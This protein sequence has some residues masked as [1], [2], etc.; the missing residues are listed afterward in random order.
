[1]EYKHCAVR[2]LAWCLFSE[3]MAL[4][5]TTPAFK[6]EPS[7]TLLA[8]LSELDRNPKPLHDYLATHN[9]VLLGSYFECLWQ[10]FFQSSPD[11][12]LLDHHI[13]IH[14]GKQTLGE[15]DLLARNTRNKQAYHI[16]LAVKF[17]LKPANLSGEQLSHWLGP[18]S[19]D[20]LDLKLHKLA[21]KQLPFLQNPATQT[22][23][24]RRNLPHRPLQ[25]LVLKGYLFEPWEQDNHKRHPDINPNANI[26]T[27]LH[28]KHG[29]ALFTKDTS[30]VVLPKTHWLGPYQGTIDTALPVLTSEAAKQYVCTH[31]NQTSSPYA[32]MLAQVSNSP[33]TIELARFMLVHNTW[34]NKLPKA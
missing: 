32:L 22:E 26:N 19:H 3:P 8:W 24:T 2:H 14:Q 1:M 12:Q 20:R 34:P 15:L 25:A 4:I 28:E 16:E 30:W 6:V 5:S 29:D 7:Q 27:W 33:K 21:N 17:Y 13:Q 31:F 23:L 9:R 18:Q 11:W 10:F